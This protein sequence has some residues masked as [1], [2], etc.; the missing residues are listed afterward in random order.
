MSILTQALM[1][2]IANALAASAGLGLC[3]PITMGTVRRA[4]AACDENGCLND[5]PSNSTTITS[6]STT[7]AV[8]MTSSTTTAPMTTMTST[9]A[10]ITT[11]TSTTAPMTGSTTNSNFTMTSTQ[12]H[13]NSTMGNSNALKSPIGNCCTAMMVART[14]NGMKVRRTPWRCSKALLCL[15]RRVTMRVKSTSY[16]Q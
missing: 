3:S 2:S 7:T 9:T 6:T 10:P 1:V 13:G 15:A 4:Q 12:H 16:M 8:P 14:K 5:E 11:M